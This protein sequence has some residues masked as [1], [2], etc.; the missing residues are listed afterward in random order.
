[1]EGFNW[2]GVFFFVMPMVLIFVVWIVF[3]IALI[4][5]GVSKLIKRIRR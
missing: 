2:W 3:I 1:M 4:L 5:Y